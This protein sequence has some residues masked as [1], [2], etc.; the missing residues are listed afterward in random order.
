MRKADDLPL[1]CAVVTKSGNLNF[2]ETSGTLR[3]CKGTALPSPLHIMGGKKKLIIYATSECELS[4]SS[5]NEL[6]V[7]V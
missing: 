2:L 5:V 3:A 4:S 6:C 1:S 7:S